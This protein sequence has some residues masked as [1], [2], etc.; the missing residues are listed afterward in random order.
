MPVSGDVLKQVMRH[1]T[2]GVAIVTSVYRQSYH[3][4]TANSFTSI[5]LNPP[6]VA[7]SIN[8]HTRSY[9]MILDAGVFGVTILSD[10]QEEISERFAGKSDEKDRFGDLDVFYLLTGAPLIIG[11][12]A[13]LDCRIIYSYGM[14]DSTL[15][16]GE[17]VAAQITDSLKPLIYYNRGYHRL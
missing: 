14:P 7:V 11:G 4:L 6:L 16:I 1:W 9:Q 3:G 17:V 8:N 2:S 10:L 12:A 15:F 5:S 13:H